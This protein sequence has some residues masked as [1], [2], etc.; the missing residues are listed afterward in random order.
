MLF[1]YI[2]FFWSQKWATLNE[3]NRVLSYQLR[4]PSLVSKLFINCTAPLHRH[5]FFDRLYHILSTTDFPS[6]CQQVLAH[7]RSSDC[8]VFFLIYFRVLTLHYKVPC[9]ACC[10]IAQN[11]LVVVY[12]P[13]QTCVA[14]RE[15]A[16]CPLV[17]KWSNVI[18]Q[19]IV[20]GC[21]LLLKFLLFGATN[22]FSDKK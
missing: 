1:L 14:N 17:D 19:N 10:C 18:T 12:V 21:F 5:T 7:R 15:V 9:G 2:Y 6:H 11:R 20:E 13:F 16:E 22:A 8:L 3:K 4:L